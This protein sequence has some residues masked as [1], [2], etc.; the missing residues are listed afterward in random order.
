MEVLYRKNSSQFIIFRVMFA[1]QVVK[2]DKVK[3]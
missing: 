3:V 1:V 2:G